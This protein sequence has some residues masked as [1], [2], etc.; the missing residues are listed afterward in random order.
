[1]KLKEQRM[2]KLTS[3]QVKALYKGYFVFLFNFSNVFNL[4]FKT[5]YSLKVLVAQ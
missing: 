3:S 4:F 5:I 1:M 2:P